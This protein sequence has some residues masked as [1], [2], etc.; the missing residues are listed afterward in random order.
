MG[1]IK[2][3]I[4]ETRIPF[5]TVTAVPVAAGSVMA[6]GGGAGYDWMMFVSVLSGFIFMHLGANV[7][8]DYFDYTGGTDNINEEYAA[9]FTG[10]SRFIQNGLLKPKEVLAEGIILLVLAV[11]F[12]A[13]AVLRF[14]IPAAGAVL[15]SLGAG[16]FY[17]APPLRLSYRGFG[18]LFIF[19]CFGPLPVLS[20]Y[21]A[22]AGGISAGAVVVSVVLGLLAAAIIDVNQFPDYK[23]DSKAGKR[24][25]VVIMGRKKGV[26]LY[27][28]AVMFAYITA[29]AGI[30]MG[31]MPGASAAA[32][33]GMFFSFKAYKV[34]SENYDNPKKLK[35]A[36]AMTA[37]AHFVT[38]IGLIA[39]Y[40][41]M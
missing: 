11:V 34:L 14:G 21:Y 5:L 6:A 9:P 2:L 18:E 12:S 39:A 16:I 4:M 35:P 7:L 37:A 10:G 31:Y 36:S 22:Q 41:L 8:N 3:Y 28:A 40:L 17:T 32:F 24:N 33:A 27:G 23:A 20:A 26:L 19:I 1:K 38:G 13:P 30:F 25:L 15:F 29:G